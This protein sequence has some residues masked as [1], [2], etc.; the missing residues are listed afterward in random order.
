M[1]QLAPLI[2]FVLNALSILIFIRAILTWFIP[3][4]DHPAM[5]ILIDLTE[6]VLRPIRR[7]MPQTMG[8]DFTPIVAIVGLRLLDRIIL[9][10]VLQAG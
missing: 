5:R 1:S 9:G 3:D 4:A 8:F 7:L 6:P 10:L 2:S